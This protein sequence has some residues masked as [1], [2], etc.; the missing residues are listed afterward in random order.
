MDEYR[1]LIRNAIDLLREDER[2]YLEI[3]PA[4]FFSVKKPLP[5]KVPVQ[6]PT[7]IVNVNT[8]EPVPVS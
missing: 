8:P 6:T 7:P 4:L 1:T 2:A 5:P 3:D